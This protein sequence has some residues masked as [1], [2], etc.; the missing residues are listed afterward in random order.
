MSHVTFVNESRHVCEWVMS[1]MWM[2]HVTHMTESCRTYANESCHTCEWVMS[3]M[4]ISHVTHLMS[5]VTHMNESCLLISPAQ[6]MRLKGRNHV[7][8]VNES[9]H[10]CEWILSNHICGSVTTLAAR[11][12]LMTSTS[13][14]TTPCEAFYII[15]TRSCTYQCTMHLKMHPKIHLNMHLKIHNFRWNIQHNCKPYSHFQIG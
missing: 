2:S 3:N 15:A 10:I 11:A 12:K 4:W 8:Y 13:K 7:A 6:L 9:R 1:H 14:C 5:H